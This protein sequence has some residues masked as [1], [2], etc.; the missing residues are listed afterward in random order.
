MRS[1]LFDTDSYKLSHFQQY[2]KGTDWMMAYLEARGGEQFDSTMF[3]GL[4]YTLKRYFVAKNGANQLQLHDIG[5]MEN[6]AAE[7]GLPFNRRG[8]EDI[9]M[10]GYLPLRIRAVPEGSVIPKKNVLLTVE[11]THPDFPW[12]V[13]WVETIL[14]RL[15]APINVATLS[16][17]CRR[18]IRS[19]LDR[20]SDDPASEIDFKLHDFGSRGCNSQESAGI[21]G[22]AHLVNFKGTDTLPALHV[23]QNEYNHAG[24]AGFSIPAS[25]HSTITSWGEKDEDLAYANMANHYGHQLFACVSDSYDIERAVREIWPHEIPRIKAMGGTLVIRPD[26][27]D[28]VATCLSVIRHLDE[29]FPCTVNSRGYKVLPPYLRVI[30]GDGINYRAIANIL[31][32]VA[33]S[34]YSASNVAFGMG[35]ELL[36]K[37]NR[38]TH[39]MAYKVCAARVDGE[40]RGVCKRPVG[41]QGKWSKAGVLDLIA[42]VDRS[43]DDN[44]VNPRIHYKTVDVGAPGVVHK[45]SVLRAVFE[46]GLIKEESLDAIRER[47]R[48]Y[49]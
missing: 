19:Y 48:K 40:L 20:T 25:E 33:D 18:L 3:F 5:R 26:S 21:L 37:H 24:A 8:W 22:C 43:W 45:D 36:Q 35:A 9:A 2:P 1:V 15:W 41:D 13:T 34:N 30:Y 39:R 11:N 28:P 27:G 49:D 17:E 7:H 46:N 14:S 29:K 10:L 31:S 42:H 23:A 38:D 47:A 16:F 32:A 4:Q 12:L 6:L 44:E